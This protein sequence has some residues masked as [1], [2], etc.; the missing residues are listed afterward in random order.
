MNI[1]LLFGSFNPIHT[2]HLLIANYMVEYTEIDKIWFV[3]SPQNPFKIND[4]LL[5]EN[6]RLQM[7]ELAIA[8]D[9]RFETCDIE[10]TLPKPSYTTLT[11]NLKISLGFKYIIFGGSKLPLWCSFSHLLLINLIIEK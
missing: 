1:G 7:I 10:F 11:L 8:D 6:L 9:E 4:D 5:D 3:V 2:G